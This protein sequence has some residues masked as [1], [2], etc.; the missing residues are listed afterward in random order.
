MG[1]GVELCSSSEKR[2]EDYNAR[3]RREL[4]IE[5]K[6]CWL[7]DEV[8][9]GIDEIGNGWG[10]ERMQDERGRGR[11]TIERRSSM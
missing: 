2:R 7:E 6:D 11:N 4:D 10:G 5:G 3:K 1:R 8:L 9:I